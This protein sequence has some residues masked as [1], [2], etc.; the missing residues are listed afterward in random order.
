[1]KKE[2]RDNL[3][4]MALIIGPPLVFGVVKAIKF[5]PSGVI[6]QLGVPAWLFSICISLVFGFMGYALYMVGLRF[7][8]KKILKKS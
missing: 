3:I 2:K 1:M 6:I 4:R 5:L 7:F 8:K